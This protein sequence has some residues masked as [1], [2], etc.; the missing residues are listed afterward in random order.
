MATLEAIRNRI[1]SAE[2]LQSVVKTMKAL[3]AAH[4]WQ[5]ERAVAALADYS[6]TVELGLQIVLSDRSGTAQLTQPS[7]GQHLGAIIL[8]SDQGMVG[9]F[10]EQVARYALDKMNEWQIP[11]QK[12][13]ILSV[14][15]RLTA[16]LEAA[17]QNLE[18][19]FS[20]PGSL[21]GVT[22]LVQELL[23]RVDAW[24]SELNLDRIVL[25]HNSPRSGSSYEPRLVQ[26]VPI[27]L[28]WLQSLQEKPWPNRVQPLYTMAWSNLFSA[29]IRQYFFG[30]IYRA[31]AESLASE[32]ASR[33]SSMQAAERNIEE[34][35]DELRAEYHQERQRSITEELLDI[36]AGSEALS[37]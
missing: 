16:R 19:S 9:R 30:S 21:A 10:N 22:P 27:D 28:A 26:L 1:E 29:L 8:G 7:L 33:L 31:V 14:G 37:S 20:V 6:Q 25:I 5:Y 4:I 36:V 12:R 3:A 35:L 23:V 34:R 13:T 24:Y 2:D 17:H 32:N 11:H 18:A 15:M